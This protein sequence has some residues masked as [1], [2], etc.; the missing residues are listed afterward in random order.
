MP[1]RFLSMILIF[2]LLA[3]ALGESLHALPIFDHHSESKCELVDSHFD[4]LHFQSHSDCNICNAL[5][6]LQGLPASVG[7]PVPMLSEI[8]AESLEK[9]IYSTSD[10]SVSDSRGPPISAS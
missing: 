10:V 9:L 5:I 4:T 2:A 3:M 8:R 7:N 6:P 1:R